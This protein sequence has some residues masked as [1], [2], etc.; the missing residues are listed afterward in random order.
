MP[1]P[2]VRAGDLNT[3]VLPDRNDKAAAGIH[4]PFAASSQYIRLC[5]CTP[6]ADDAR[7]RDSKQLD[8]SESNP[9][10]LACGYRFFGNAIQRPRQNSLHELM[11]TGKGHT[12]LGYPDLSMTNSPENLKQIRAQVG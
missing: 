11:K 2:N 3:R 10:S 4:L 6:Y 8:P 12:T 1:I 7:H 5:F 9:D